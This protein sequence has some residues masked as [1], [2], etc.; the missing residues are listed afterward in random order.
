MENNRRKVIYQN[1]S[2]QL[3]KLKENGNWYNYG[4]RKSLKAISNIEMSDKFNLDISKGI[5]E[6]IRR[7]R[8]Q[9][10]ERCKIYLNKKS[11]VS[12]VI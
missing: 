3:L 11:L 9:E 6:E 1:D 7:Y 8:I 4:Q 2:Y 5:I 10:K 12:K